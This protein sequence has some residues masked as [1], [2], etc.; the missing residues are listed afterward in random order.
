MFNKIGAVGVI[1][2]ALVLAGCSDGPSD[3]DIR[4]MTL[5][6]LNSEK[7]HLNAIQR[8]LNN[9][10]N[11]VI[12]VDL[13]HNS[14]GDKVLEI[15]RSDGIGNVITSQLTKEDSDKLL[16]A[17][18]PAT[19]PNQQAQSSQPQSSG[20]PFMSSF[21]GGMTGAL[22]GNMLANSL[23]TSRSSNDFSNYRAQSR[24]NYNSAIT[25][26]NRSIASSRGF[27][28]SSRGG[29]FS[30]GSRGSSFGG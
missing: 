4:Q 11:T 2:A 16:S 28:G 7:E 18:K 30:S 1:G 19:Q 22:V 9:V 3:E 23:S 6:Q 8:A 20:D 5:N 29:S 13:T 26:Q 24:S 10:D 15:H 12:G 27:S 17:V 21:A 14:S 25:T